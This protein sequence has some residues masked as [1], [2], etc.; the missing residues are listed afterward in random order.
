M[1]ARRLRNAAR[2]LL[3][4]EKAPASSEASVVLTDDERIAE[5]NKTY[6]AVDG[7]TDVLAFSQR[8]GEESFP[9]EP[10][11]NLLG[12]VVISVETARRQADEHG[13]SLD[14]EVEMLLVHGLLHLMGYD[15]AEP[16]EARKMFAKQD[17]YLKGR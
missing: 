10:E 9:E 3:R 11:E 6:R 17:Q 13:N 14:D 5:L 2:R 16:E 1:D 4:A 7:P 15:H 8:E 12:D